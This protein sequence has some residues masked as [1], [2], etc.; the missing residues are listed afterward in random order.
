MKTI[1]SDGRPYKII[2]GRRVWLT[3]PPANY[4]PTLFLES[5]ESLEPCFRDRLER[6][7]LRF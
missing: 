7:Y 3:A 1:W 5:Q 2:N 6:N 4:D